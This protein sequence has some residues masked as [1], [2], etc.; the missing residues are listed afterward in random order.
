MWLPANVPTLTHPA[1]MAV[2]EVPPT[3]VV[4]VQMMPIRLQPAASVIILLKKSMFPII[5]EQVLLYASAR[6]NL[7]LPHVRIWK[8]LTP[9]PAA[10]NV[11]SIA[12]LKTQMDAVLNVEEA[13]KLILLVTL[14]DVFA[15]IAS[16]KEANA[17]LM[18]GLGMAFSANAKIPSI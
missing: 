10:A 18:V 15:K 14:R 4:L 6:Q 17:E 2:Q 13:L 9:P 3:A 1:Q 8:H 11:L 7:A 12:Q 5:L 16:R